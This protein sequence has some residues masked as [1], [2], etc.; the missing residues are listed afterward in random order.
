MLDFRP[1]LQAIPGV[2]PSVMLALHRTPWAEGVSEGIRSVE[3]CFEWQGKDRHVSPYHA[4]GR[5]GWLVL[6]VVLNVAF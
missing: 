3:A 4:V 6:F 2:D 1:L 5:C